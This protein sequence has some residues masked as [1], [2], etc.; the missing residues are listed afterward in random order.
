MQL[1]LF[2]SALQYYSVVIVIERPVM[3][4]RRA[5]EGLDNDIAAAAIIVPQLWET[6]EFCI[7]CPPFGV[8]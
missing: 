3:H 4:H 2:I 7:V 1:Q 8:L 6:G 5:R